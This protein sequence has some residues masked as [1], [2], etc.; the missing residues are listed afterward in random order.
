MKHAWLWISF[1]G[2]LLFF[3][4]RPWLFDDPSVIVTA[5]AAAQHPLT[6]YSYALDLGTPDQP[7]WPRGQGP[8]YTHPPFSAWVMGLVLHFAGEHEVPLHALMFLF[9]LL[10]LW[11]AWRVL[12][13]YGDAFPGAYL[14]AFSPVLFLTSL[15]LYPH[16]VYL[17]FYLMSL[18]ILAKPGSLTWKGSLGFAACLLVASLTLDHWPVLLL[19]ALGLIWHRRREPGRVFR[20]AAAM[21][22]WATVFGAWCAWETR[23]YGMPH[24]L[25]TLGVRAGPTYTW[26]AAFLPSVFLAG[27]LP[28][29]CIA[30]AYLKRRSDLA[31]MLLALFGVGFFMLLKSVYGGFSPG[32]AAWGAFLCATGLAFVVSA[33]LLWKEDSQSHVRAAILWFL[34]EFV[35]LQRFLVYPSG[36]HLLFLVLPVTALSLRMA[37]SLQ[38]TPRALRWAGGL[39]ALWTLALA[40]ADQATA[41]IGP[42]VTQ[43]LAHLTGPRYV[44]GNDFSGVTYYLKQAGWKVYDQ[45]KPLAPGEMLLVPRNLNI[46]GPPA[47]L[48][49]PRLKRVGVLVYRVNTPLRTFSIG[50]SAGWYSASWGVLPFAFSLAPA[51]AFLLVSG[52]E[53][54]RQ[55]GTR[56][57][58]EHIR[59]GAHAA[60]HKGLVEFIGTGVKRRP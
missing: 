34:L 53:A 56:R 1:L 27:G 54:E 22:L 6:P 55:P 8:A 24:V 48:G 15:T 57:V 37:Q 3:V 20:S 35:F 43:E 19:L 46:Q 13:L 30:W 45:R 36:H 11:A 26:T 9:A 50:D 60:G 16:L 28:I 23:H 17:P 2:S 21:I 18:W 7:I 4:Q 58:D 42:R 31:F 39:L 25:A 40:H 59:Q 44:W 52:P 32:Q 38:L 49:N 51:E 47:F 14:V 12:S 10:S 41:E 5:R 29:T 33:G